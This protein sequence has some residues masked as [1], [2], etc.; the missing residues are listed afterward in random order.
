[1]SHSAETSTEKSLIEAFSDRPIAIILPIHLQLAGD[2]ATAAALAQVLY[3]RKTLGR[4]FDKPDSLNKGAVNS[5]QTELMLTDEQWRTVKAKLK[6][7]PFLSI[8]T[9]GIPPKTYYDVDYQKLADAIV[10]FRPYKAKKSNKTSFKANEITI[11]GD[12]PQYIA[13]DLPQYI[14]G[15]LPQYIAGDLPRYIPENTQRQ[16]E[17]TTTPE[18]APAKS[19]SFLAEDVVVVMKEI[20]KESEQT[21]VKKMLLGIKTQRVDVLNTL[22]YAKQKKDIPNPVGYLATL[23]ESV[24]NGT[25]TV[26]QVPKP[27]QAQ[28][29]AA[30]RVKREEARLKADNERHKQAAKHAEADLASKMAKLKGAVS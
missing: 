21:A 18:P 25:F 28:E 1:M 11:S 20:F 2:Y 29:T 22:K 30:E 3:W 15:D 17:T 10:N 8:V 4:A 19:E 9:K 26:A 7:L 6:K 12:L 16:P 24:N 23:C 5:W 27:M 14:S 13:G